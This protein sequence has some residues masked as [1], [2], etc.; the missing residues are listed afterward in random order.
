MKGDILTRIVD[1]R[2]KR[3]AAAGGHTQGIDLPATRGDVPVIPFPGPVIC[4]IKR[5]SPS[6][7]ELD[8]GLDPVE[9]AR[10]YRDAGAQ[11][12]SVLTE[13]EYFGGSLADLIAVKEAFPDLAVLR[14]DFLVDEEDI[15]ASW[16]SG[17]DAVLL[18]AGVLDTPQLAAM[19]RRT[20]EL[21]ITPLVEIHN[22]D[23]L[24]R[25]AP[26]RPPVIGINSRDLRTFRVDLLGPL[27]L[28]SRIDWDCVRVFESGIFNREDI[29]LAR[30]GGF[31]SVLVGESVVRDPRRVGALVDESRSE[32]IGEAATRRVGT[33]E[34][35]GE[36]TAS[37]P[38]RPPRTDRAGKLP[39]WTAL[40]LRRDEYAA[41]AGETGAGGTVLRR[42]LV[43]ICGITSVEDALWAQ[44]LGADLLGLIYAASPRTAP[45]GLASSLREAGVTIPLV[46][47]VVEKGK[48]GGD[49]VQ[50]SE[51]GERNAALCSAAVRDLREGVLDAIQLHGSSRPDEALH[52]GWPVYKAVR[53]SDPAAVES[54]VTALRTPRFLID[55]YDPYAP[56]GTGQS[57]DEEILSAVTESLRCRPHGALWLAGGLNPDTIAS[58]IIR[59]QPE[60][61]DASSGLESEPGVKDRQKME[62]YFAAIDGAAAGAEKTWEEESK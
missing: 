12:V 58:A 43:K 39:F 7:G 35:Q 17:A 8:G 33:R 2:R 48:T 5:R 20:T 52:Y 53:F 56:G 29:R 40:A 25:V 21:G 41:K 15:V 51:K 49:P 47:V 30:D 23:E 22:D 61:V 50:E 1:A 18:I 45:D 14:K 60:L 54:V 55:A 36:P 11:A 19:L 57:V 24:R 27:A 6:R 42:P 3:I 62:R 44:R 34:P 10:R 37:P 38:L 59:W 26:L 31:R 46:G 16:R 28:A 13:E 32:G 4:E 9:R